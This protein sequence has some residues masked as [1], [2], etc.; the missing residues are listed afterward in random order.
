M[1]KHNL[2]VA[3]FVFLCAA[4][5]LVLLSF[6]SY[7]RINEQAKASDIVSHT[8]LLKF[9]LND[10]F[11]HL[12]KAEAAQRGFIITRD[13][14]F[15]TDYLTASQPLNA[16][17]SEVRALV[18]N[19]PE[20]L[21]NFK[22]AS[23]IFQSRF[24]YIH[25]TLSLSENTPGKILDSMM[26]MG[27]RMT[28]NLS[29]IIEKMIGLEDYLLQQRIWNMQQEEKRTSFLILLLSAISVTILIFSFFRVKRD[30]FSKNLLEQKIDE[31]TE[32]LNLANENLSKQN[33]Q[34][35]QKNEELS[36]FTFIANHDLKEPLRKV[37][38]FT[39]MVLDSC[40]AVS[41]QNRMLLLKT[42][43]GVKRMKLLLED[44]FIY[45]LADQQTTF[46]A[47]DLNVIAATAVN[48]LREVIDEKQATILYKSLPLVKAIPRQMEQVFTNIISNALKYSRKDVKPQIVIEA[49]KHCSIS[50]DA[51]WKISFTDNGLGFNEAYIEKIFGMFQRLH[52]K[53]EYPGTGMGLTICK[54]IIENH[55]GSITASSVVGSGSVFTICLP[56]ISFMPSGKTT[57]N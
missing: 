56:V 53:S 8:Q 49:E 4:L 54:K 41:P 51:Y 2:R 20:Q 34:L 25:H 5:L 55:Q 11:S 52:L 24:N 31:R 17:L 21:K 44:I 47:T 43:E 26:L 13:S 42:I 30:T 37:E 33:I 35:K 40:D 28:D 9:K 48:H 36:S 19:N 14:S 18:S 1:R 12:I 10:A 22:A 46:D 16:L 6:F 7:Q 3:N 39:N 15:I 27:K 23:E 38:F 32:E 45:T 29:M 50:K 57:N